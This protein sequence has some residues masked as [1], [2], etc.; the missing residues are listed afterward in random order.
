MIKVEVVVTAFTI[1]RFI[2]VTIK[3]WF[4]ARMNTIHLWDTV[5]YARF[6]FNLSLDF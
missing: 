1:L 5:L 2:I 4:N 3:M 6:N